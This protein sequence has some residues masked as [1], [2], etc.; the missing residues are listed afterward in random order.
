[1]IVT[2][3]DIG[4]KNLGLTSAFLNDDYSIHTVHHCELVDITKNCSIRGCCLYHTNSITD[5]MMHF[6][7][8]YEDLL[9]KSSFILVERQIPTSGLC[10]IQ[11]LV[12][13]K[14]RDKTILVCPSS[15]HSH[16]GIGNLD[17]ERRKKATIDMSFKWLGDQKE[18]VFNEKKDDIADS[19][20][21]IKYFSDY[22]SK[23]LREQKI[24]ESWSNSK[25]VKDINKFRYDEILELECTTKLMNSM[26][27]E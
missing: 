5:R 27:I 16:F 21:Y 14:Y 25:F 13:F 18:F 24:R 2:S 22:K 12:N 11:E 26:T 10:A 9:E 19:W 23:E 7:R 20:C 8:D 6:F 15:M 4:I 3:I 1:M 17:Y